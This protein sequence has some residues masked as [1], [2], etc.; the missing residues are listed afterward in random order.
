MTQW[1]KSG[2]WKMA[3]NE[4]PF[5]RLGQRVLIYGSWGQS[6]DNHKGWRK[7]KGYTLVVD[8]VETDRGSLMRLKRKGEAIAA[9]QGEDHKE[10][11]A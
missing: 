2:E 6:G 3:A 4:G 10:G 7:V 1:T 8:G 9:N 11:K 5:Y